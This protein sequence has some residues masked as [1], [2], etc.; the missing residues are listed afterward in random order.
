MKIK[1][2]SSCEIEDFDE[3]APAV[4]SKISSKLIFCKLCVIL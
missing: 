1:I 2:L 4:R 3:F